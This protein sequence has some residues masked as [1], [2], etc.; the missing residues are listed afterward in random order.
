MA[1]Y[2]LVDV[3]K[4]WL[5]LNFFQRLRFLLYLLGKGRASLG[6]LRGNPIVANYVH[7]L[8]PAGERVRLGWLIWNTYSATI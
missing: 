4:G 8:L 6:S 1:S 7:E 3:S 2:L 5:R